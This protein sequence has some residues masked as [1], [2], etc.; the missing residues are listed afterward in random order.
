MRVRTWAERRDTP[1]LEAEEDSSAVPP[2][3]AAPGNG[4]PMN[5]LKPALVH[6]M[7]FTEG[8][9]VGIGLIMIFSEKRGMSRKPELRDLQEGG[10]EESDV[11]F[12][13]VMLK[14][15]ISTTLQP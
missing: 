15:K 5:K 1:Q 14:L 10:M 9:L 12:C 8:Q 11:V 3:L 6:K 4:P 7:L 2:L 13:E